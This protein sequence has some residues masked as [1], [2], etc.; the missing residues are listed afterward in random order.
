MIVF[1]SIFYLINISSFLNKFVEIFILSN[2]FEEI[3]ILSNF[4]SFIFL[5]LFKDIEKNE[6]NSLGCGI[7]FLEV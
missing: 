7:Y 2:F 6:F 5:I 1:F 3:F 4:L